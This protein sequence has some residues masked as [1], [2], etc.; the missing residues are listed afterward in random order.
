MQDLVVYMSTVLLHGT[1]TL[2]QSADS[3]CRQPLEGLRR[4]GGGF[5]QHAH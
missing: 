1:N 4:P 5:E 2:V 3:P